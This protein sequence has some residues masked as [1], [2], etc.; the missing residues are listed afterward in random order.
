MNTSLSTTPA[1][2]LRRPHLRFLI[3][4]LVTLA[5]ALIIF[6]LLMRPSMFEMEAMA[7][8][9]SITAGISVLAGYG[10]YRAGWINRSPHISWTLIGGYALASV[11]TF[12]NVWMTARL[13]FASQHDLL[14]ATVLL[15][16]A[17]GIAMSLGYFMSA[18]LND[19]IAQLNAGAKAIAR[20][21]LDARVPVQGQNEMAELAQTFN[22]MAAQLQAA[23]E[24]QREMETMRRNLVAWAGHDLRTPL[25]S[26]QV[27]LEALADGVVADPE[28]VQR[29][30]QTAQRDVDTLSHLIDDLF[31]LAQFDAGGFQLDRHPTAVADLISNAIA[32]FTALAVR[33]QLIITGE[34]LDSDIGLVD[35]DAQRIER[36]LD[37]LIG[38]ALRY[39]PAGGEIA[40]RVGAIPEGVQ[41]EVHDSG[42]GIPP[43]DLPHIFDQFYR[44]EKSRSRATGGSGLGLAISKAIV[45]AHGGRIWA[46]NE[47]GANFY[48][49]LPIN[50]IP[51]D[52]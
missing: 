16:F 38:N 6:Y 19:N 9:L 28:T 30:L 40:V 22:E 39:T 5:G 17:G 41:I 24:K 2:H 32:R 18:A 1:Y 52:R 26:I 3:G 49:T 7:L 14:L 10:A 11:L 35:I 43:E 21:Q 50:V 33:R 48:F 20:G 37:N 31:D 23:D 34:V 8:F 29:Y 12:L 13:M 27:M 47:T 45:E 15:L 44:G 51:S 36:V 46:T 4:V 25:A 42:E